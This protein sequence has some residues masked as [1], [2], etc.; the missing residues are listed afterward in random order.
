MKRLVDNRTGKDIKPETFVSYEVKDG[1]LIFDFIAHNSSLNSYSN[2]D[3]DKLYNGDV[4]EVF[5]DVGD[6]FYYEF[7]V[8]PNGATFVATIL[9]R[10]I[11]FIPNSFFKEE[12]EVVGSDYKVKMIIDLTKLGKVKQVKFN[13]FRIETKGKR[14]NYI[15]QALSPTLS[16]TFHD[17]NA[18]IE[19]VD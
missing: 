3:N 13:A 15:L 1:N 16:E 9:N 5:L 11:T 7:E 19:L 18:F 10:E 17:K 14:P 6:E 12:V 2:I 8:A 4:V